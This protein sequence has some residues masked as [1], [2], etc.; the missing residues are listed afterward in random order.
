[1]NE[2][3]IALAK[4]LEVDVNEIENDYENNYSYEGEEYLVVTDDEADELQDESFD[5]YLDECI[6]NELPENLRYYFDADKWK[7]DA[8]YDGRG[9]CL[10]SYDGNENEETVNGTTYYIYRTN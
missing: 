7:E 8:K 2:K 3:I 10:S 4:H 5:N 9:H 1:M 6:L